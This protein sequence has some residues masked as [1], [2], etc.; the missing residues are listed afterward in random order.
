VS[1]LQIVQGAADL[2]GVPRPSSVVGS[3]DQ[4]V[5]QLYALANVEGGELARRAPQGWQ[6]LVK[7]MTFI[8]VAAEIQPNAVASDFGFCI[9]DTAFNRSTARKL[10]GPLTATAW[11]AVK[12]NNVLAVVD[13]LFR[14]RGDAFLLTP[15]PSAGETIAYE[16]SSASWAETNA[17]QGRA[18]FQADEDGSY[19]D[20]DLIKLG[21]IW[22]FKHAKGL[23][24]GEDMATYERAV[25][26]AVGRDGGETA[27]LMS[28]DYDLFAVNVPQTIPT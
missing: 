5:R 20:E 11:Q 6:A 4:Q 17:G 9:A 12:A 28:D 27:L 1:L 2:L 7:E 19:L 24:Y 14:I 16:Y 3:T 25:Q 18:S 8:T 26:R 23:D 15:T 22:R 10:R 13:N 21:V